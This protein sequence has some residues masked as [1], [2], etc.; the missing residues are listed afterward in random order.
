RGLLFT[1]SRQ[2]EISIWIACFFPQNQ[3]GRESLLSL[4]MI[5]CRF[6]LEVELQPEPHVEWQV[7]GHAGRRFT[8][9]GVLTS[10]GGITILVHQPDLLAIG[11]IE[12]ITD[13][14]QFHSLTDSERIIGVQIQTRG[15]WRATELTASAERNLA[16][17]E[18]DRVG[19]IFALR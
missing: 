17:V 19:Q 9:I 18:I 4:Q 12:E 2:A 5:V 15:E 1:I 16:G 13:H 11:D 10:E 7:V 6:Y 8:K 14:T 3:K